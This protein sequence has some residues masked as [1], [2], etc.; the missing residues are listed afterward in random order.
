[1]KIHEE[2]V[3]F[4]CGR[5]RTRKWRENTIRHVV[6]VKHWTVAE[7]KATTNWEKVRE[8]KDRRRNRGELAK[9]HSN[10]SN[11]PKKERKLKK[12]LMCENV[13]YLRPDTSAM[14]C[15]R[16][17]CEQHQEHDI[18]TKQSGATKKTTLKSTD[19]NCRRSFHCYCRQLTLFLC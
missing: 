18:C 8:R 17:Q 19:G 9:T 16:K 15:W 2:S 12:K 11:A 1:M 6:R 14:Q 5:E 10:A 7:K 3:R 13:I 4:V